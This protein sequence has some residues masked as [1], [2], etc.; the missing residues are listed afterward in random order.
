MAYKLTTSATE[1]KVITVNGIPLAP[2]HQ[3]SE[4]L[5]SGIY[6]WIGY[7]LPR[8]QNIT[9]A[10]GQNSINDFWSQVEAIK[11]EDWYFDR[12]SIIRGDVG[13][14]KPTQTTEDKFL[15][16]GKGYLIKFKNDVTDFHWYDSQ[17][18]SVPITF[19]KAE[20]FI[21]EEKADYEAIDLLNIPVEVEEIGVFENGVCLGAVAVQDSSEQLLVYSDSANRDAG[22]FYFEFY[23]NDR[24]TEKIKNYDVVNLKSGKFEAKL[25][26]V[27]KNEYSVI[28]FNSDFTEDTSEDTPL[29]AEIYN[30]YPNPFNP[31][32]TI[33]FNLPI[34]Q[35][36]TL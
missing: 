10:F 31:T 9:D 29:K 3:I 23:F 33:S 6:H 17:N 11:S 12:Q 20:N 7:W 35:N 8:T 27:G 13:I 30:N 22:D 28:R 18:T 32:T 5:D 16:Y 2:T 1:T 24:S 25:L 14:I 36:I 21:Y 15:V 4:T 19:K 34:E 26:R